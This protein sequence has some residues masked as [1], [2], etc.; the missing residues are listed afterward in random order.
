MPSP[1]TT[2]SYEH[3]GVAVIT[4]VNPPVNALHPDGE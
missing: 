2:L 1:H 3:G 4:L